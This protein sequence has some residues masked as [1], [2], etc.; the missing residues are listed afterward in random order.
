MTS[1]GDE[2]E[3]LRTRVANLERLTERVAHELATPLT[4]VQGF[5][6]ILLDGNEL[7][8]EV[9]RGLE[10]IERAG[11]SAMHLLRHRIDEATGDRPRSL[12]LRE[13][14]R[15]TVTAVWGEEAPAGRGLPPD[16]R[17]FGDPVGLRQALTLVLQALLPPGDTGDPTDLEVTM[18]QERGTAY[19]LR[20]DVPSV[21]EG[22]VGQRD[23]R[24]AD[25]GAVLAR[26]GG[27]LWSD[28]PDEAVGRRSVLVE[29]AR[30]VGTRST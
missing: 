10:R 27:R 15:D 6:R 29:L 2:L 3:R 28:D 14:V 19:Q 16:A 18:A 26:L 30:D 9:R 20:L 22:A 4:T 17:V 24:L 21:E 11:T 1:E 12:R 23:Q 7:P 25:A 13:L 8:P 5:A